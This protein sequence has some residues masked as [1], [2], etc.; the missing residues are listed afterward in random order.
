MECSESLVPLDKKT[1]ALSVSSVVNTK[2]FHDAFEKMPIPKFVAESAYEQTGRILR[3]TSGTNFEYMV[4]INA[5]TG[6]LVA[7]NL[8]RSASE[9]KTSFNDR[10]MWRV[11][12][13][14]DRVTIVHNHPSSRPPSYRDVYTAAKEEKISAS[15][16]VGHDGSLWYISIG[17]ANIAHQLE[18]AYNARK[19]YYGNFAENKA[20][21]MLLKENE[22]HNLFIWRRLR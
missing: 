5:R 11:Q 8:Y 1:N 10:E 6:E 7:D 17:D 9:K 16:I 19:D 14:P 20:L 18:S 2:A 12:K 3:A 21:D 15:I 13:C 22:T 4:A